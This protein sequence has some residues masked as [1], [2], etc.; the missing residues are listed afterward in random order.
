M[1]K[2][3]NVTILASILAIALVAAGVGAGTMAWFSTTEQTTST[4][5]MNA[6][7]MSMSITT[8]PITFSNLVPGQKFGPIVIKITNTG[9]MD[10]GYLSGSMVLTGGSSALAGK[11]EVTEWWEYIPGV[12]WTCNHD[13]AIQD[14]SK[15]VGDLLPPLTLLEVAQS[16]VPYADYKEPQT[17]NPGSWYLDQWGNYVKH[18]DDWI[19]GSGYDQTTSPAIIVGGEYQMVFRFKF[20]EDAGNDLQG[21]SV[22]FTITFLGFQSLAQRP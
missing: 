5:T 20:S 10:I 3:G 22:S 21:A 18:P 13:P 15:L 14:Y 12:G 6:A 11:I 19:S 7:T 4:Y 8:T 1:M 16:Y 17:S 2:K 9:T